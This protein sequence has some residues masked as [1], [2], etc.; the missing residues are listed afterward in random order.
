MAFN[1]LQSVEFYIQ[2][3]V[4]LH[5]TH[6][7]SY[8]EKFIF[9]CL[10]VDFLKKLPELVALQIFQSLCISVMG[11]HWNTLFY[12]II[13]RLILNIFFKA[14]YIYIYKNPPNLV[15]KMLATK[16]GFVPDCCILI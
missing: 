8:F 5:Q 4:A 15:A 7:G 16:F 14:L 11:N 9:A 1:T 3:C 2:W 13:I 10:E 6:L 12:Y